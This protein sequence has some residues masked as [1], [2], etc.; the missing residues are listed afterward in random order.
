MVS[1]VSGSMP[2]ATSTMI[3]PSGIKGRIRAAVDRTYTEGTAKSRMLLPRQTSRGSL[4]KRISGGISMP[5][6]LGCTRVWD[7]L[8][9]SL[10]MADH[11]VTWWPLR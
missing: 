9:I 4:V 1:R 2:L 10:S 3:C 8:S 5:G 6:R 7:R 11:T